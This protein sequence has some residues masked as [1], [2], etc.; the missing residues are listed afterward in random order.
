MEVFMD[1]FSVYGSSF[2]SCLSNLC[3]VLQ[4]CVH[5][6]LVLNWE[7]YHFM[8]TDG[9]VLG[10]RISEKGIEVDKAKIKALIT[11]LIVQP[12]DWNLPFEVMCDESDFAIGA[13]LGQRKDGSKV[14]VHIDHAALRYLLTKKDVKLRLL[15]WILLLQE[16]DL[17]IRDKKGVE[18]GVAD[19]LSRLRIDEEI[20]IDDRLLEENVY[21]I[22]AFMD[23][24][25]E[26]ADAKVLQQISNDSPWYADIANYF[27]ATEEPPNFTDM[28]RR[29]SYEMCDATSG[30]NLIFTSIVLTVSTEDVF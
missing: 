23:C 10:H 3:K 30:M 4:C 20:P 14:I 13:V 16:F 29:S 1:D 26:K 27:C 9:I 5:K 24:Y 22:S 17:E 19:H 25:K 11:A 15:R 6:H 2:S 7:K 21:V 12:P 18:N 28:L 8:V